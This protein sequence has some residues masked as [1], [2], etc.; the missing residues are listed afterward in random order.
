MRYLLLSALI[1]LAPAAALANCP[2]APE[3]SP[4]YSALL[5]QLRAAKSEAEAQPLNNRL[6]QIW[7]T[8][9]DATAQEIL[10][11][12]MQRRA[13]YDLL[14]AQQDFDALIAYCP[15]YA[16]GYNQRAFVSFIRQAYEASL[17][18]LD[19]TLAIT[20][21]HVGAASG[22]ALALFEL[23]RE[24]EAQIALRYALS[25]HPWLSERALLRP[26]EPKTEET[27]L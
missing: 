8:A 7:T 6:W 14:G 18:D 3:R 4:E 13:S 27:E 15:D 1:V 25:L 20:P 21:D 9:P 22:R 24:R 12:G 11:R 16:E 5:T 23:G 19:R 26:L 10:A 17:A 2:P